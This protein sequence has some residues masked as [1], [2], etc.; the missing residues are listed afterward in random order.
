MFRFLASLRKKPEKKRQRFVLVFSLGA[1][2]VI[3]CIWLAMLVMRIQG[4]GLSLLPPGDDGSYVRSAATDIKQSWGK[5]MDEMSSSIDT[6]RAQY[7]AQDQARQE[8]ALAAVGSSTE[9]STTAT[10]TP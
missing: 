5:F 8:A 3:F 4:G 1:T 6:A 9:A 7:E 2:L 10:T